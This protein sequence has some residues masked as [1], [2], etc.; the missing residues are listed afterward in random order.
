[1]VRFSLHYISECIRSCCKP[2]TMT[3]WWQSYFTWFFCIRIHLNHWIIPN[4]P[5]F[6]IN[7]ASIYSLYFIYYVLAVQCMHWI[8]ST[9]L[10]PNYGLCDDEKEKVKTWRERE[11]GIVACASL[12]IW[13]TSTCNCNWC[14]CCHVPG[15]TQGKIED[16]PQAKNRLCS[17]SFVS[18]IQHVKIQVDSVNPQLYLMLSCHI[19]TR[20]YTHCVKLILL[21]ADRAWASGWTPEG[22]WC[23]GF[24]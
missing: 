13:H 20:V 17:E 18:D 4:G 12:S 23:W 24:N 19:L 7:I 15:K 6:Y 10:K 11:K 2:M 16:T 21:Y 14:P 9:L 5:F 8:L 1:M 22:W 3:D